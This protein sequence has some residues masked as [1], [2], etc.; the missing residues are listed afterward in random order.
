MR[1]LLPSLLVALVLP[2]CVAHDRYSDRDRREE[3][4]RQARANPPPCPG[5]TWY[6]GREYPDGRWEPGRWSCGYQAGAYGG[7]QPAPYGAPPPTYGPPAYG[8]S[9]M[10]RDHDGDRR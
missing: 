8:G 9:G 10:D 2:A 7:Y 4:V 1:I 5:A 3:W 6:D